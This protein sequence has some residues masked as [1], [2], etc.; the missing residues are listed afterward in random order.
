WVDGLLFAIAVGI[1]YFLAA[2]LS[3]FLLTQPDGVAVFWP[4][5]GVSSG[6]LIVLGRGGRWPAA[7]G[8]ITATIA[9][10]LT[11][12]RTIWSSIFFALCNAGEALFTAWLI[13]RY[14]GTDFSLDRV[15]HVLWLLTAA[16]IG[17]AAS[18][19]AGAIGYKLLHSPDAPM[20]PTW[21][22]WFSSD[23]I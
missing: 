5:A 3:L 17:T 18:G 7:I 2:R 13:E 14:V 8:T 1:S 16:L 15:R 12:D 22:H 9:A 10:N 11:S 23:A 4:A 19:V 6:A 21:A 20:V